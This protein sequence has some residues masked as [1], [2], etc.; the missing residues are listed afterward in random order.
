MRAWLVGF[1]ALGAL[2]SVALPGIARA[3]EEFVASFR[4]RG[5][6]DSNPLLAPNGTGSALATTEAAFAAGREQDGWIVGAVGE[7]A[8]THYR[9]ER[10]TPVQNAKLLLRLQNKDEEKFSLIATAAL[11]HLENYDTQSASLTNRVRA[12]W[13]GGVLRP[14]VSTEL[15]FASLNESNIL[16]GDFL[17]EPMR[18]LRGTITTGAAYV[19]DK[20]E[21]GVSVALSR[22]HYD[23]EF[24][25]FGF[26]RDND[27][28]QP[29]VFAR[30][31]AGN[32]ELSGAVSYLTAYSQDIDFS[33]VRQ[34]LFELALTYSL[35]KWTFELSALRTA[36][37]TTF[38]ISPL[39]INTTFFGKIS[40]SLEDDAAIGVFAR[41]SVRQYWDT[42]FSSTLQLTG[43][44]FTRPLGANYIFGIELAYAHSILLNGEK[45]DGAIGIVGITRRFGG[46]PQKLRAGKNPAR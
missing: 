25:I 38:P 6:Y 9:D 5:G 27:R 21:L 19:K 30:Y 15:R 41:H 8:Y 31:A 42:P 26:R 43:V 46:D 28:I 35:P 40:H 20:V 17:P 10:I 44:E 18:Y 11:S 1:F 34:T 36:E 37:D 12:Q 3:E 24:D 39:T 13:T 4:L 16:F 7:G 23:D 22:T 32:L 45:A 14:F 29:F 2:S 33:D